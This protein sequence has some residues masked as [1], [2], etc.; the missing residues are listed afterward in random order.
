MLFIAPYRPEAENTRPNSGSLRKA[1]RDWSKSSMSDGPKFLK[2]SMVNWSWSIR[3][4]GAD[5]ERS[6]L[7]ESFDWVGSDGSGKLNSCCLNCI[8]TESYAEKS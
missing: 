8:V 2:R 1:S 7:S 3:G 5:G 4:V 6:A